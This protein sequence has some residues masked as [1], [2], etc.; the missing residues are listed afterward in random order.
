MQLR[1]HPSPIR[2]LRFWP[3]WIASVTLPLLALLG[4][5]LFAWSREQNAAEAR[6]RTSLDLLHE[7]ALRAFETQE[8]LLAAV[9]W[10][11]RDI[12]WD[13]ISADTGIADMLH[14]LVTHAPAI[15]NTGLTT[16]DGRPAHVASLPSPPPAV[17]FSDRGYVRH[18]QGPG[19]GPYLSEPLVTRLRGRRVFVYSRP[20][21]DAAGRPDGGVVWTTFAQADFN[22]VYAGLLAGTRDEIALLRA[23][24]GLIL[25]SHPP[26]PPPSD[27]ISPQ[28]TAALGA[29][30]RAAVAAPDEVVL[31]HDVSP[32][33]GQRRLYAARIV[34]GDVPAVVVRGLHPAGPVGAWQRQMA[35]LAAV[36]AATALVL[37]WLTWLVRGG[38]IRET[39]ALDQARVEAE[40]RAEAEAA[41][42]RNHRLQVLGEVVAGVTHDFRNTVQAVQG[43][44]V[45]ARKAIAAGDRERA[46]KLLE[47]MADAAGRGAALTDRMLRVARRDGAAEAQPTFDPAATLAA[48]AD[49]LARTLPAGYPLSLDIRPEGLPALVAGA[50]AEFEAVLLNLAFNARDAM[51]EGGAIAISLAAEPPQQAPEGLPA[52]LR[53]D[54]RHARISVAD[55]GIGMDA[56]TLA[57]LQEAF[58]TT[59]PPGKGTG[60]G[61]ASVRAFVRGAGGTLRIESPGPGRGTT[62]TIWLPE[63]TAEPG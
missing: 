61:L 43:G 9:L 10:R 63:A 12:S 54:L 52:K 1:G 6:L 20:R 35:G 17:D 34:A 37:L 50:P 45:L 30:A 4:A 16:P 5:A 15:S 55:A 7:H 27:G 62:V 18:Q 2:R 24:D 13:E 41:L 11:I 31:L 59:K 40:H 19:A 46:G 49:L 22:A 47:L 51:P 32:L 56:A 42:R 39:E 21:L 25:A 33:D 3:L 36:A 23:S 58:F 14:H 29:V 8:A 60:L 48:V 38:A 53:R 44:T 26:P 28:D 57:R